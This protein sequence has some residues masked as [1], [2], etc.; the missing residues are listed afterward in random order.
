MVPEYRVIDP[1]LVMQISSHIQTLLCDHL[2]IGL[3]GPADSQIYDIFVLI[4]HVVDPVSQLFRHD[5]G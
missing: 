2:G 5:L 3:L 4:A 1:R